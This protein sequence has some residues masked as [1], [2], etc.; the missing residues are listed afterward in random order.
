MKVPKTI[1]TYC[2]RCK[3]HTAHSVSLYKKGRDSTLA[4]GARRY[5]RKKAGY[6]SQPKPVQKR[7]AKTTKK[8]M[9]KLKCNECGYIL[10]RRGI[11][12]KKMEIVE[13]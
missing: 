9:I 2:P 6:G 7:F 8:Q 12:L 11:R 4:A 3:A 13:R 10:Q 1:N 5:A